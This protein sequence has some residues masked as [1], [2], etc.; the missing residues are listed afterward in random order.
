MLHGKNLSAVEY[1]RANLKKISLFGVMFGFMALTLISVIQPVQ[2][3]TIHLSTPNIGTHLYELGTA[4]GDDKAYGQIFTV[5]TGNDFLYDFSFLITD[6]TGTNLQLT[7]NIASWDPSTSTSS[8]L[9]TSDIQTVSG[10]AHPVSFNTNNLQLVDGQQYVAYLSVLGITQPA[11]L[12]VLMYGGYSGGFLYADSGTNG[13]PT[14]LTDYSG[15]NAAFT[16][17]LGSAPVPEPGTMMLLGA[18]FLGL[19]VYGKRRKSA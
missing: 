12:G 8:L 11:D 5:P 19:A 6:R 9:F 1:R 4:A 13:S 15:L 10:G 18:G 3:S 14:W 17:D 2:A 16:A 7:G